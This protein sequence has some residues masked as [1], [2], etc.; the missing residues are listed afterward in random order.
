MKFILFVSAF[1]LVNV[2]SAKT[3]GMK[4]KDVPVDSDTSII[5]KKGTPA[6]QCVEY[7]IVDGADEISGEPEYDK[8]EAM[9]S[10]KKA[11]ADWKTSM[12]DM[13]KGNQLITL[14]CNSAK[15]VKEDDRYT[16]TSNGTYKMKLKI[17]DKQ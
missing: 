12:R 14:N 4:L 2:A 7:Q 11:C 17:R 1:F 10:W 6:D 15:S 9:G 8:G 5:I 3:Q 13:N 16:V